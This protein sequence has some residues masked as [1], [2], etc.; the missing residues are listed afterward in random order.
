M[1][2]ARAGA[3][4]VGGT[5]LIT[6]KINFINQYE[7]TMSD[8][9]WNQPPLIA[10]PS[11]LNPNDTIRLGVSDDI[12]GVRNPNFRNTPLF[13]IWAHTLATLPP[14][15]AIGKLAASDPTPTLC[16]LFDS[17]ACFQ[18]VDRPYLN[19]ANGENILVYV[20]KP[21]VTIEFKADMACVA[22]AVQPAI[23]FLLT[24]QV[25]LAT[26]L[27]KTIEGV[28]GLLTRI[29]PVACDPDDVGLPVGHSERYR[30][31]CW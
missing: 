30:K 8:L 17:T 7:V 29:E 24:V 9:K 4:P 6:L 19:E 15:N 12:T 27:H 21:A 5:V 20:I 22:R 14:I 25:V 3:R 18:G 11:Y 28:D 13:M 16:T 23:P 26:S 2:I 1:S 10:A 31:R